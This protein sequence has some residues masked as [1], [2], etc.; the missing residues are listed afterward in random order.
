MAGYAGYRAARETTM[1][2]KRNPKMMNNTT[3]PGI[4]P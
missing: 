2:K 1:I 3:E 4:M